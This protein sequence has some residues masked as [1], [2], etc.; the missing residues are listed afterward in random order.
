MN[1]KLNFIIFGPEKGPRQS[2]PLRV[3]GKMHCWFT[4]YL[5]V[6]EQFCPVDGRNSSSSSVDCG[7]SQRSCLGPLLLII[8]V[9][10]FQ[11]CLQE[12]IP[13]IRTVETS[14]TWSSTD[15]I[16]LLRNTNNEMSNIAEWMRL[17]KRNLSAE[18]SEFMVIGHSRQHNVP[19][20]LSEIE[21]NHKKINRVTKTKYLDLIVDEN[22]SWKD[23]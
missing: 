22:L 4:S 17:N 2:R 8:H 18:T 19:N 20:R 3:T 12:V 9:N 16:A 23:L 21:V 10:Y 14:I 6:R 5:R 7:I 1:A 11:S 15:S 13:N